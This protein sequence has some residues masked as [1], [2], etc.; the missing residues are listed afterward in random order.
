VSDRRK[1]RD[2]L[3]AFA[4]RPFDD[5]LGRKGWL[6]PFARAQ[7]HAVREIPLGLAGWPRW[8]RPL[9]V[10]YLSDLHVGSHA[11]D[12]ARLKAIVAEAAAFAPDLVLHGGDFVNMQPF[13]GGRVPPHV[14]AEILGALRAPA[15]VFAVLGNHDFSY[16]R[17]E[18]AEALTANGIRLL[19][20]EADRFAFEG[21]EIG[22]IGIEDARSVRDAPARLLAELQADRPAIVLTHDPVWFAQVPRGP[23]LTLAGHTHGGQIRLPG[24]GPLVNAS[25]APLRWT[26]GLGEEGGRPLYVTSGLGTSGVPLRIG[27]RPEFVIFDIQGVDIQGTQ[28]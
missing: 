4:R 11:G 9:R 24:F 26:Y 25:R 17:H 14:I 15:G 28:A 2:F 27:I 5:P 10:A 3:S 20:D 21:S 1:P 16:G 12:V 23:F 13:G 7:A 18:V 19:A 6:E 8:K 22:V